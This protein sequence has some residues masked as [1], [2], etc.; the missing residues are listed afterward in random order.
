MHNQERLAAAR[1]SRREQ[2]AGGTVLGLA[3]T[4]AIRLVGIVLV[5]LACLQSAAHAA[6]NDVNALAA[7]HRAFLDGFPK[8]RTAVQELALAGNGFAAMMTQRT[9]QNDSYGPV[10][11]AEAT[12]WRDQAVAD[13]VPAR[14]LALAGQGNATAMAWLGSMHRYALAGAS[15]DV[16]QAAAWY[17]KGAEKGSSFA[18]RLFAAMLWEGTGVEKDPVA[19]LRWNRKAADK[20]D[21]FAQYAVGLAYE[22]GEGVA[23]DPA[24]A[25]AWY[26]KAAAQDDESS[27]GRLAWIYGKGE[28]VGVDLDQSVFWY[29]KLA[30]M[31][32]AKGQ[33]NLAVK[34]WNGTGVAQDRSHALYWFRKAADQGDEDALFAV[35]VVEYGADNYC[36]AIDAWEQAAVAMK[37]GKAHASLAEL[38]SHLGNQVLARD[39]AQRAAAKG[40][41]EPGTAET[42]GKIVASTTH[43]RHVDVAPL[44]WSA[45]G[46]TAAARYQTVVAALDGKAYVLTH[47]GG[48]A[49][50][51]SYH[52]CGPGKDLLIES[53]SVG[54]Y[55]MNLRM[56]YR[57]DRALGRYR[58]FPKSWASGAHPESQFTLG[59]NGQL[60]FNSVEFDR[61]GRR[62]VSTLG[63]EQVLVQD[64]RRVRVTTDTGL[65]TTKLEHRHAELVPAANAKGLARQ[66]MDQARAQLAQV[67][68]ERQLEQQSKGEGGGFMRA[69]VGATVGASM[70]AAGGGS[71]EQV[72]GGA[73]K[74][75]QVFNPDSAA[76]ASLGSTADVLFGASSTSLPSTLAGAGTQT[77]Y[78]TR[79]SLA[80]GACAGFTE[81]NYR[82]KALTGGP[83]QQLYALCGQAFEYY[84][85]YKRAIAQGYSEADANRTYA[86]HEQSARVAQGFL[87]SHGAD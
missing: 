3:M 43:L 2:S 18:Q 5:L 64:G 87:R 79:P 8:D 70:M 34:Y 29:R 80:T 11:E 45:S 16:E 10:S 66:R 1:R 77:G 42:V 20:G 52:S 4:E 47:D 53:G 48:H 36:H 82:Q 27:I 25:I 39:H 28:G 12:R 85:M 26:R 73:L 69:L 57:F 17:R 60:V 63:T 21:R 37:T 38:Y 31:G 50:Y 62:R 74:G 13:D 51:S 23:K 55:G 33:Y 15:T 46:E 84:T 68:R 75:A 6:P 65:F 40:G 81:G 83:D 44:A 32:N 49:S 86:A 35:G 61:K 7:A 59:S 54:E 72:L 22:L 58:A 41:L 19:A 30:E 56:L 78:P 9:W 24:Q 76:A 14:L 67:Q 71:N